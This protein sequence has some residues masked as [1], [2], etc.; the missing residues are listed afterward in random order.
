MDNPQ[1][2]DL[3]LTGARSI[4]DD[5]LPAQPC[6][7]AIS[8]GTI[9]AVSSAGT[10][11]A[12]RW[13][14]DREL[15]VDGSYL[16]A[17]FVDLH[18]HFL[19]YGFRSCVD[20]DEVCPPAGVTTAVDGGSAGCV[21]FG[22]LAN[23]IAPTARTRLLG[24]VNLSAIGL[25]SIAAGMP[26]LRGLELAKVEETIESIRAHPGV[27]VGVKVRAD[28]K[29]TE[30][31]NVIPAVKMARAVAAESGTR[32]MVHI[33]DVD[34]P[35]ASILDELAAG[36]IVTH[37][38]HGGAT[39]LLG[40]DGRVD[41]AAFAARQRGVLFD[42]G[43]AGAHFDV[44]VARAALEQGLPPDTLSSDI[45]V[46]PPGRTPYVLPAIMSLFL[47]LGLELSTVVRAV[48]TAPSAAIG[49][50]DL[51]GSIRVGAPADLTAFRVA[52][53]HDVYVDRHGGAS[54]STQRVEVMA[55]IVAGQIVFAA[56]DGP[57]AE[58]DTR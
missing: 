19:R 25:C 47:G 52:E 20:A 8:G 14:A 56:A 3:V 29:A 40:S 34:V 50:A 26:E 32:V 49:R 22:V 16:S 7:L 36:D 5:G 31:S 43:H 53:A 45:H 4:A 23:L 44:A 46:P 51:A 6:D 58:R 42:V 37:A 28:A 18:G 55:T 12:E 30:P 35:L 39:G 1:R 2:Y 57:L 17:G 41:Q 10:A 9:A 24:F 11:V 15:D 21:N 13:V 54:S 27:A 38:Y 48:T 33:G